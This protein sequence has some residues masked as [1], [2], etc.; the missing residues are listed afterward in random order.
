MANRGKVWA[1]RLKSKWIVD[2]F[3]M[4]ILVLITRLL[5]QLQLQHSCFLLTCLEFITCFQR[6]LLSPQF[7]F[8]QSFSVMM[9]TSLACTNAHAW[10]N[11]VSNS[12]WLS[13]TF[14]PF[15]KLVKK[16]LLS[17]LS[18]RFTQH[19]LEH[20]LSFVVCL[21]GRSRFGRAVF[22]LV[23]CC[24]SKCFRLGKGVSIYCRTVVKWT[25]R[26]GLSFE[27]TFF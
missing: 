5:I 8:W 23:C 27:S 1:V 11:Q 6:H 4:L 12:E 2:H 13:G 25:S 22:L 16:L 17:F 26:H 21:F 15:S 14:C 20:S 9:N 7:V 18:Y 10:I 19:G 3:L 24:R